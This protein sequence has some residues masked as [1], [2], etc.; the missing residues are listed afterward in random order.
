MAPTRVLLQI[1][2][3]LISLL[4]W[5][6]DTTSVWLH[7]PSPP[8]PF[9]Q[10]P[11]HANTPPPGSTKRMLTSYIMARRCAR[12]SLQWRYKSSLQAVSI[13]SFLSFPLSLFQTSNRPTPIMM[14]WFS[15]LAPFIRFFCSPL[16]LIVENYAKLISLSPLHAARGGKKIEGLGVKKKCKVGCLAHAPWSSHLI[17]EVERLSRRISGLKPAVCFSSQEFC[18]RSI[19]FSL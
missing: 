12:Q 7:S 3:G 16:S 4:W 8:L 15:L 19:F 13:Q 18:F 10:P 9:P 2:L 11:P 6:N 17:P 14:Y 1:V 5:L